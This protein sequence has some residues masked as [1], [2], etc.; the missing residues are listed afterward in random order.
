MENNNDKLAQILNYLNSME[1]E[2]SERIGRIE[3]H[4]GLAKPGQPSEPAKSVPEHMS[5]E[6]FNALSAVKLPEPSKALAAKNLAGEISSIETKIGAKYLNWIGVITLVFGVGFFLKYAFDNE[7]VGP[8][9][10]VMIGIFLGLLF[11][12]GGHLSS[13]KNYRLPAWGL[14]GCGLSILYLSIWVAFQSY[15]LIG[16]A[17][18]FGFMVHRHHSL[19]PV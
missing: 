18:S 10:R 6:T 19:G 2:L 17:P 9:G 7:W 14:M 12:V 11:I 13:V 15:S 5:I 4:L 16:Q 1:K 8:T 3:K